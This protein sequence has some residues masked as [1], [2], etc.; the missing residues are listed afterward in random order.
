MVQFLVEHPLAHFGLGPLIRQQLVLAQHDFD[1]RRADGL[2]DLA[3]GLGPGL[4]HPGAGDL[5]IDVEEGLADVAGVLDER[6]SDGKQS[7]YISVNA[8]NGNDMLYVK[9][10]DGLLGSCLA[11]ASR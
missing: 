10:F 7:F 11:L 4:V 9:N 8:G 2:R 5:R 3:L 6:Y 1:Q